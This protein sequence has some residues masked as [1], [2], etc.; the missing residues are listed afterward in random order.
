MCGVN[1][2]AGRNQ[3]NTVSI[4]PLFHNYFTFYSMIVAMTGMQ[5]VTT[6]LCAV[7]LADSQSTGF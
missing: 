7:S 1:S 2:R 6:N 4:F 5:L 3:G